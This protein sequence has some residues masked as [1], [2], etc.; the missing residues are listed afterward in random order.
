M[1]PLCRGPGPCPRPGRRSSWAAG[2]AIRPGC[3]P[4]RGSGRPGR[5]TG[6]DRRLR[7]VDRDGGAAVRAGAGA[8]RRRAVAAG[9]P[10][11]AV[12]VRAPRAGGRPGAGHRATAPPAVRRRGRRTTGVA[13]RVHLPT[14]RGDRTPSR[15][16]RRAGDPADR[17]AGVSAGHPSGRR[18]T[19]SGSRTW[20]I[21]AGGARAR[22]TRPPRWRRTRRRSAPG[23]P[24]RW[25]SSR[26]TPWRSMRS[27]VG[28]GCWPSPSRVPRTSTCTH[29]A[30][31]AA[32][33]CSSRPST[34]SPARADPRSRSRGAVPHRPAGRCPAR[35]R[36]GPAQPG[37]GRRTAT[38]ATGSATSNG[39][40]S[41]TPPTCV[42]PTRPPSPPSRSP[43]PR[44]PTPPP[45]PTPPPPPR[46]SPRREVR[47][48]RAVRA[49]RP[50]PARAVSSWA[51]P[52]S[53]RR[54]RSWPKGRGAASAAR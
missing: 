36:P 22:A 52:T 9:A 32:L 37:R 8:P 24:T 33:R 45:S 42:R 2:Y 17:I 25:W 13:A 50:R 38:P 29:G 30:V 48:S 5:S 46:R 39:A 7:Y 12:R 10:E 14:A 11:A 6:A 16:I 19:S 51:A 3:P 40:S 41:S 18:S 26:T 20:S 21:G 1:I 27:P 43:A 49:V 35:A 15:V 31:D 34:G 44:R 28:V 47:P 23:S 53:W 54:S 4:G